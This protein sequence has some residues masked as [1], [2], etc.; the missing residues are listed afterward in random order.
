MIL[1]KHAL[2][3]I[4]NQDR[5]LPGKSGVVGSYGG[6]CAGENGGVAVLMLKPL[7]VQ[8]SAPCRTAKQKPFCH[9]VCGR[10]NHVADTLKTKHGVKNIK[11]NRRHAEGGISRA[12]SNERSDRAGLANSLLQ[13]L[14]INGFAVAIQRL[15]IDRGIALAIGRV[16]TGDFEEC[17]HPEGARLVR[18]YGHHVL[19]HLGIFQ[20]LGQ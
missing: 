3:P 4:P 5:E 13:N 15:S 10:P 6:H 1:D 20:Q 9:H 11:G 2:D 16:D 14:A 8:S 12:G 7:A 19:T 17:I 18:D